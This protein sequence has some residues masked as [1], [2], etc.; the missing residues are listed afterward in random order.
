MSWDD[1]DYAEGRCL[2][3]NVTDCASCPYKGDRCRSQCMEITVTYNP[4]LNAPKEK[5]YERRKSNRTEYC[6]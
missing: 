4:N 5:R 2:M 6:V 1:L 3:D